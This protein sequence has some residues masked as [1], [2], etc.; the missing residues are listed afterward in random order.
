[1][2]RVWPAIGLTDERLAAANLVRFVRIVRGGDGYPPAGVVVER[3]TSG[4]WQ[5]HAADER[6][7]EEY[8][9]GR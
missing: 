8:E 9:T 1:V 6:H 2:I 5:V 4:R 7:I 3:D